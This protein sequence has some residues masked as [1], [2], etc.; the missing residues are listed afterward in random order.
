[1]C[2]YSS[3]SQFLTQIPTWIIVIAGWFVVHHL[4][5]KRD[6]RKEARERLDQYIL[7]LRALEERAIKFHQSTSYQADVAR[8]LLFDIQRCQTKLKRHPFTS[9]EIGS[10]YAMKLRQSVSLR[11]FDASKFSCQSANS[12]ILNDIAN[13]F[14]DI[15]DLLEKEYERVYL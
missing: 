8:G 3:N 7:G 14:D 1:M 9:F 12:L 5:T 4:S 15:E 13:A 6:Q 2:Q 11:N 10:S